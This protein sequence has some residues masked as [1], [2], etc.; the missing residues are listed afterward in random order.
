MTI[1][2][3]LKIGTEEGQRISLVNP[4]FTV[5]LSTS[6]ETRTLPLVSHNH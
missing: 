2:D 6:I 3:Y 1:R 5:F 4:L